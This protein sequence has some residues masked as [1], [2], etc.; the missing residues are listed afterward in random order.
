MFGLN[1][2][3]D[4]INLTTEVKIT[5]YFAYSDESCIDLSELLQVI[6]NQ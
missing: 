6:N 4:V 5:V 3:L 1:R 2:L